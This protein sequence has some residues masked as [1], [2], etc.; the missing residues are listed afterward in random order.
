MVELPNSQGELIEGRGSDIWSDRMRLVM[1]WLREDEKLED[2]EAAEISLSM[3]KYNTG[4][5]RLYN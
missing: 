4:E 3:F 2:G 1:F 5:G